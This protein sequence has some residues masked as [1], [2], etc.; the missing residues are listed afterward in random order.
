MK[1]FSGCFYHHRFRFPFCVWPAWLCFQCPRFITY[2]KLSHLQFLRFASNPIPF[3]ITF[4]AQRCIQK[5]LPFAIGIKSHIGK[6]AEKCE[7]SVQS[8]Y[9]E[10]CTGNGQYKQAYTHTEHEPRCMAKECNKLSILFDVFMVIGLIRLCARVLSFSVPVRS[11]LLPLAKARKCRRARQR[12]HTNATESMKY[13][14]SANGKKMARISTG[15][16]NRTYWTAK[17]RGREK[18]QGVAI[19]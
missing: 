9:I 13:W 15:T 18:I 4:T 11:C 17:R 19:L 14:E 8:K 7:L 1:I 5:R 3:R 2:S 16:A 12:A 6:Q 10:W